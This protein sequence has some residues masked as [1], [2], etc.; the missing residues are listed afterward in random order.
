MEPG[1]RQRFSRVRFMVAGGGTGGH[2]FPGIA[3]AKELETRF[4][5]VHVLFVVGHDRMEQG[6]LSRY[7]YEAKSIDVEGLKGR[8]WGRGITVLFKLPKSFFQSMSILREFSP[9]VVLGMGAYSAGPLC[10][11]AKLMGIP[12]AIHEQNSYPGFTNRLLSGLVDRVFIS[13]EESRDKIKK[14]TRVVLTG[15]PVRDELFGVC[16][17]GRHEK[18]EEGKSFTLLV[19]GGSQGARIFNAHLPRVL[20]LMKTRGKEPEVIHQTGRA[21]YERVKEDYLRKGLKGEVLPFIDDM[22]GAYRRADLVVARA[23]ATT[24]F[25]LAALGKPSILVPFPHATNDHQRINALTL[26]R[27]GAAEMIL[28]KEFTAERLADLLEKFMENRE[29]LKVMA[30]KAKKMGRPDAA[31]VIVD[32]LVEMMR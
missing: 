5:K 30:E 31:W 9:N 8:G 24:I 10:L 25:E 22:A 16:E 11:A 28:Q 13:F 12:T 18:K 32:Q 2:L 21:D 29:P 23:G 6:I 20:S 27:A 4:E 1:S 19:V 15:N 17:K 7:G 26:C 3:V 14:A